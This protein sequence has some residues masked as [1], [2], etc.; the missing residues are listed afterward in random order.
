ML[1]KFL[2]APGPTPVPSEVLLEM[3]KPLIHHRTPQFSAIIGEN[4]DMLKTIF[5]TKNP[6]LT[7][8]SS[9]TGAMESSI[10]NFLSPG[11]KIITLNGG[12][13]GERFG[14]IG[15]AYGL[16][17]VELSCEWGC[18]IKPADVEKALKE[19]P[20]TKAVY[21][22][23]SETCTAVAFDVKGIAEVV[24]KTDAIMV[25]DGITGIGALEFEMDA[26]G[27]DVALAGS[28]KSLM[29]PPGL[30]F[31]AISDKA[32][33]MMESST[34]PKFYFDLKKELKSLAKNSTTW[35][36]AASLFIG[37]NVA[38]KMMIDEGID[39]VIKRHTIIANAFRKAVG[40]IDL[41]LLAD[42]PSATPSNSVTAVM[43][44]EGI[45]GGKIPG[46]MRDKYGVT[47]AGGQAHLKGKIFRLGH[48]GYIDKSDVMIEL[49]ALEYVLDE[50]GYKFEKGKAVATAQ[51]YLMENLKY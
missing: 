14:L 15:K 4:A 38:L 33:K 5:K 47:I 28:Q 18:D 6:V 49:Q 29:I 39:N 7:V 35:T 3:A 46:L 21:T 36:P 2:C 16:D 40:V 1:K 45:D 27:I 11:D 8:S 34:L 24:K 22:E 42:V 37:L 48:L 17:V 26:W 9:G 10:V 31:I 12:K 13:F 25:A 44:P 20:D 43:V 23:Y 51:A 32:Q 19:N 50:L 30:A 41:E